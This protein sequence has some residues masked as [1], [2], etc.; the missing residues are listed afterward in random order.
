MSNLTIDRGTVTA[1]F[2]N[3]LWVQTRNRLAN[4][5]PR[6]LQFLENKRINQLEI[7]EDD[8][9]AEEIIDAETLVRALIT[10]INR[11]DDFHISVELDNGENRIDV[12]VFDKIG[13]HGGR[14]ATLIPGID[15][16]INPVT[17]DTKLTNVSL[18]NTIFTNQYQIVHG[19][20]LIDLKDFMLT[21]SYFIPPS[22]VV[23]G[24]ANNLFAMNTFFN[25]A[26]FF[27][28]FRNGT[29][30]LIGNEDSDFIDINLNSSSSNNYLSL[31]NLSQSK[32]PFTTLNIQ[33]PQ[34]VLE[35]S[36]IVTNDGQRV[37]TSLLPKTTL[38]KALELSVR[39]TR[40]IDLNI[41]FDFQPHATLSFSLTSE[42]V[43][44]YQRIINNLSGQGWFNDG[45]LGSE[46]FDGIGFNEWNV[47]K[48]KLITRMNLGIDLDSSD[49]FSNGYNDW[50]L[51]TP[52]ELTDELHWIDFPEGITPKNPS[53][54]SKSSSNGVTE[55]LTTQINGENTI[56]TTTDSYESSTIKVY[57]NGQR[58]HDATIIELTSTTFR[59][60]FTPIIGNTIVVDYTPL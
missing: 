28:S 13:E 2:L 55:N 36:F 41:P 23:G 12:T 22:Y 53:C 27:N 15:D 30:L 6:E 9:E 43:T 54:S 57:W 33:N 46:Q 7:S 34:S 47:G 56:F 8:P 50:Y 38:N 51:G 25:T 37:P 26:S 42:T 58:Q 14:I 29:Q 11:Q 31:A 44:S 48:K 3:G 19:T 20:N 59:T 39:S 18:V 24:Q 1:G 40:L 49:S 5:L 45:Y 10:K 32:T 17:N 52:N 60:T 21:D 35:N 4:I 16:L